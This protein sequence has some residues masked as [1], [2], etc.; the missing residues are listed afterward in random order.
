MVSST[1]HTVILGQDMLVDN[2]PRQAF[3]QSEVLSEEKTDIPYVYF[4]EASE[5]FYGIELEYYKRSMTDIQFW[6]F[7]D[8]IG[9]EKLNIH[10]SDFDIYYPD[11]EV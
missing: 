10:P 2:A 7:I 1:H 3:L 11:F 4:I 9:E 6:S 5:R 8:F